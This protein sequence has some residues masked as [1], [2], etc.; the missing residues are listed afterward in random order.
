VRL[1]DLM[2]SVGAHPDEDLR[3][4]SLEK[5]GGY[6]VTEMGNE[7][8]QNDLTLVALELNG[9]KLAMDHG[10]PARMIAPSRPG[11]LQTKWLSKLEVI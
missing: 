2:D 10:Y 4:T 11:V 1:R 7:F 8:V 9:Q 3:L 6:R 5:S